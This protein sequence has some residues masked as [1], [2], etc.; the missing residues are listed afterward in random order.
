MKLLSVAVSKYRQASVL[1]ILVVLTILL[2]LIALSVGRYGIGLD[3]VVKIL[4]SK[5]FPIDQTWTET[6]ENVIFRVRLPRVLAAIVVG[7]S[8]ALS[9][10]T[11]Q[12]LFR[13]PLVSPDILG[14]SNGACIGAAL[15]IISG[16]GVFG[17]QLLAFMG[18][19]VAVTCTTS[20]PRILKNNSIIMLVLSGVIVGGFLSSIMG[21]IKYLA[22]PNTQLPEIVYW[23]LGS[24]S[25]IKMPIL[26]SVIPVILVIM[27][28]LLALRWR[29][30]ILSLG[31]NDAKML[32][33]NIGFIRGI[34]IICSTVLTAGAVCLA[35][36]IGWVG[37]V[38]P[39]LGRLIMGP[40]NVKLMPA[41]IFLGA[42]FMLF[43]DT[44]AR[45]LTPAEIPLSI[46]TGSFGAVF[47]VWLL[48]KQR[49]KL[50]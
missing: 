12:G 8:L 44:L 2:T 19:L 46:L 29:I 39:H 7:S 37:L 38:M 41:T 21:I 27:A 20:I 45:T 30:N 17:I 42:C 25:S 13:N 50:Q 35:G 11:F 6:V 9:G 24:L 1:T 18:G 5:I 3:E 22:D 32:G 23:M 28:L 36:T 4:L 31:D 43:V 16:M 14:V 47:F 33:M 48:F 15:A 26:L 34:A 49:V 10:A 40:D